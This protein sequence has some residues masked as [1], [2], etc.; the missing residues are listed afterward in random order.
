MDTKTKF[1]WLWAAIVLLLILNVATIGWVIRKTDTVRGSRP[2]SEQF[3][4]K[5]LALTPEQMTQYQQ[6]HRQMRR[7]SKRYED[8]LRTLRSTLFSRIKEP[9]V[10][11]EAVNQL[12]EQIARQNGQITRLRFRHWQQVRALCTPKQQTRFDQVISRIERGINNPGQA[13]SLRE[14]LRNQF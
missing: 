13:R 6:S 9:A 12:L 10:S 14:R 3:L 2:N 8:S 1:Y 5:R 4:A 7:Q 11:D